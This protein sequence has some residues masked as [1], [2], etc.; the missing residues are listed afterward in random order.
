[1]RASGFPYDWYWHLDTLSDPDTGKPYLFYLTA[2]E[3]VLEVR[4]IVGPAAETVRVVDQ[5]TRDMS[6]L[7]RQVILLTGSEP[8]PMMEWDME[9]EV[10]GLVPRLLE[11][12]EQ[13]E[14]EADRL[15]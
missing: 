11:M 3:H 13:L 14:Y 10:P 12:A 2:G 9:K 5:V 6:E 8:D 7:A 4:S 1:M 15:V